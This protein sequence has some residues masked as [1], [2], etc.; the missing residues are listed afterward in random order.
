MG[1]PPI[2]K[3]GSHHQIVGS[4]IKEFGLLSMVLAEK[5]QSTIVA[6]RLHTSYLWTTVSMLYIPLSHI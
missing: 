4:N 6:F 1:Q 5:E 3:K 2:P